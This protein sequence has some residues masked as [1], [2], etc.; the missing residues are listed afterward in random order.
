MADTEITFHLYES[1]EQVAS[2]TAQRVLASA[3][4]AI[5][6]RGRF[7]LV[8]AGGRTPLTA[9]T[10]LADQF[11]DWDRWHI[12]FG[13]ERCLPADHP[14][15]NSHA[16]QLAF[17][18]RVPIPAKNLHPIPAELGAEAAAADYEALIRRSLPFDLV[19]L[20]MGE[21]GHTASLFPGHEIPEGVLVMPVHEAP[22]PPPDRV[23][24]TPRALAA[25]A[26]V[27]VVVTGAGKR[28][29]LARWR[30]GADLPVARVATAGR[31][32]V[33]MDL[34]AAGVRASS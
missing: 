16:A 32:E 15:R 8:L 30:Q 20:G 26:R 4:E 6:A 22:K 13:D 31:A 12:F 24:L 5:A 21:D 14:E 10:L 25:S 33:L 19:L 1:A 11:S 9:Y 3:G 2:V 7:H 18:R 29:A 23:S 34:D 27:L 28:V 17:L